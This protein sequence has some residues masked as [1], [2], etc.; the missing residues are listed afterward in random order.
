MSGG[1]AGTKLP[2]LE[3]QW[4]SIA[5][6]IK[7]QFDYISTANINYIAN[8]EAMTKEEYNQGIIKNYL[9]QLGIVEGSS[10]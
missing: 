7:H 3:V 4:C 1:C 6:T 8:E 9:A 10:T 5:T 2:V